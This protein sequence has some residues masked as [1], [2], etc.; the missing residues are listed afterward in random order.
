MREKPL[1]PLEHLAR[2]HGIALG[3]RD[4]LGGVR[5]ASPDTLRALLNGI[6]IAASTDAD[7][8]HSLVDGRN[9]SWRQGLPRTVAASAGGRLEIALPAMSG[10]ARLMLNLEYEDGVRKTVLVDASLVGSTMV[11]GRPYERRRVTLPADM[12]LGV[13]TLLVT[14]GGT[15]VTAN[16][17]VAPPRCYLP[18]DLRFGARHFGVAVQLYGLK[19]RRNWGM[20][21]FEDLAEFAE[22]TAAQGGAMVG[23]NPLHALFPSDPGHYGPYGPSSRA[24]LNI[25]Y[26][27]VD[28]VPE[29]ADWAPAR[30]A[31]HAPAFL[32]QRDAARSAELVDYP[33]VAALK[34]PILE[35]LFQAFRGR[36]R[37]PGNPRAAAFATFTKQMGAALHRHAT[38]DALHEHF[39]RKEG[40]WDWHTWPE[41][42]RRFDSPQV[43]AFA[44]EHRERVEFFTWAQW[45][46]DRQ[47]QA[48]HARGRSAGMALGLYQDIAVASHP[49]GSMA[50]SYPDAMIKG[51]SVGA[52]PDIINP[53][54][55]NWGAAAFSPRGLRQSAYV[56]LRA[57]V[58]ASM[59]HAGAVRVDHVFGMQRLYCVPDGAP[60]TEGTYV[61]YPCA[62][63]RGVVALESVRNKCLVVGEDLGTMPPGFQQRMAESGALSYR[64]YYFEREDG[65]RF[66]R[67]EKFPRQAL[68]TATTHDLSTLMGYWHG[69]D[70]DWRDKLNFYGKP[71]D[72]PAAREERRQDRWRMIDALVEQ[73]LLPHGT[74]ADGE[75]PEG[76]LASVYAALA[77][78]PSMLLM[79]A[80]EDLV[81]DVEQ[82]NLPG[83]YQE[84]PNWR[85]RLSI[86]IEELRNDPRMQA[87]TAAIRRQRGGR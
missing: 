1:S 26:I 65:G 9:D 7:V 25:L 69:R 2:R 4:A 82:P 32:S 49:G 85:R 84:H 73:G 42:F 55:Q 12:P 24:F 50:W 48:A 28:Q 21:D 86:A 47:L 34:L 16:L 80:A 44:E 35:H 39:F 5:R 22:M 87:I 70:L 63:T 54:G 66:L 52:P 13:H 53:L 56:P 38:F 78:A 67:P 77:R 51:A 59:R 79:V 14:T 8:H 31:V 33:A 30:T 43:R 11:D 57:S 10:N 18:D 75:L 15:E 19:S 74:R 62:E 72:K 76:L 29:F 58:A 81:G 27:A 83:T 68:V 46:A 61:S 23:V 6:G 45:E 20:G 37:V 40:K 36:A 17:L 64:V 71:E 3:Y 41:A 60:A